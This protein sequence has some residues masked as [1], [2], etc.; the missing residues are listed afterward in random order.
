VAP[1]TSHSVSQQRRRRHLDLLIAAVL[2]VFVEAGVLVKH[3]AG[4]G[5]PWTVAVLGVVALVP[6]AW[7]HQAPVL[8]WAVSGVATL[9]AMVAHGSPGLLALGPLIALYTVATDCPRRVSLMAGAVSLVGVTLGV[10]A[11][12]TSKSPWVAFVFPLV[13]IA[14]AWLIGDN[15]RVRRVYVAELEAK[16][17]RAEAEREA[18]ASRAAA[19]E[20]GRIA[21]ELH[22]VVAHHVS[23]IA[24]QAGAARM[25]ADGD[26]PPETLEGL[27]A[28]EAI[29]RQTLTELRQLLGV[30]R[31][32]GEPPSLTPQPGLDQLDRLVAD[33]RHAGLPVEMAIEG[34]RIPI[35]PGVDLSAYRIIQEALTNVLKHEGPVPTKVIVRFCP[36]DLELEVA[37]EG[38]SVPASPQANG[39]GHGLVGMR[40]RVAMFGGSFEAAPRP[41]GGF[42]VAARIPLG[43]SS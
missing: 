14:A 33:V 37:D 25:N 17:A 24:V 36:H 27:A 31:H 18:E 30:L 23:V 6:L 29:A 15:L 22:D 7:R 5:T 38:G 41:E 32:D 13:V 4:S 21:R 2:L 26:V 8:V 16:A 43:S 3:G 28:V 40:E 35:P 12:R 9:A 42:M 11:V 1:H 19:Q 10:A 20:R 34:E 39:H